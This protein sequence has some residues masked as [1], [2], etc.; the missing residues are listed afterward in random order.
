MRFIEVILSNSTVKEAKLYPA[1]KKASLKPDTGVTINSQA[2][3]HV[4]KDCA[5]ITHRYLPLFVFGQYQDPIQALK[6]KFK[7]QDIEEFLSSANSDF[8]Y[9]QLLSIILE[10]IGKNIEVEKTEPKS[11]VNDI[12]PDDPYGEYGYGVEEI[13]MSPKSQDNISTFSLL[14]Q[15]FS[16]S[17]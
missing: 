3:Y 13:Q 9:N 17:A 6:G 1:S 12:I 7:K 4:I 8:V 10:K 14:C 15:A 5:T 16:V 2:A 11:I